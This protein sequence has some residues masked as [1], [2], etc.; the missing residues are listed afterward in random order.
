MKK[1][2]ICKDEIQ[3]LLDPKTKAV[4]WDQGHNAYPIAEGRCCDDCNWG[5]VIPVRIAKWQKDG[6]AS[7]E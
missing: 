7:I 1:C 6:I 5:L 2:V 4:V 3:P